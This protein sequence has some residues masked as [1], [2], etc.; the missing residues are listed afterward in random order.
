VSPPRAV[1]FDASI[2][3]P[4]LVDRAASPKA[5]HLAEGPNPLFAPALVQIEVANALLMRMR[6]GL[7]SPPDYPET[8]VN[9]LR[10]GGITFAPDAELLDGA[11]A[12]A[13]RLLHPIYDCLY[14]T[15]AR[16][17]EAMLATFDRRLAALA[18]R[19]AVPLWDP[20]TPS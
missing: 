16:R 15:L 12:L 13:R 6:R 20:E 19:L 9:E 4:W 10:A 8:A 1:V 2:A 14:L 3:V 5:R 17:E 18:A 11:M 7:P